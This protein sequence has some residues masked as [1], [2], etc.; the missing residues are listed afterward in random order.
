MPPDLPALATR[1]ARVESL[2]PAGKVPLE[3]GGAFHIWREITDGTSEIV[4]RS[5]DGSAALRRS[6]RLLYLCGWPDRPAMRRI[7]GQAARD[8]G[9]ATV[10]LP[11]GLRRTETA[12]ETFWFNYGADPVPLASIAGDPSLPASLGAADLL[13]IVHG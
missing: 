3:G 4:E 10:D 11:D 12:G 2:R 7:L 8:A 6:G 13:R 1:V 5:A 9:L